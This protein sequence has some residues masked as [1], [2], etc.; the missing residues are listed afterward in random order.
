MVSFLILNNS[1]TKYSKKDID[2]GNT[3]LD[4][5][6]LCSGIREFFCLSY[7]IRKDNVLYIYFHSDLVLI[8]LDGSKLRFLGSDE[9]SQALLLLK[10]LEKSSTSST[11]KWER[12]T[13]GFYAMKLL[14]PLNIIHFIEKMSFERIFLISQSTS[15]NLQ[16]DFNNKNFTSQDFFI[17]RNGSEDK[18]VKG[19]FE[20]LNSSTK[21]IQ[22]NFSEI[23]SLEN[24]IL[25]INYL[26]DLE[27]KIIS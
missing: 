22:I 6:N 13:P 25:Y 2:L 4:I 11:E 9:R 26:I 19:L 23:K 20:N 10:V 14:N 3:P 17:I 27:N 8:K 15:T 1:Y 24:K 12:S 18:V 16:N 5:Y 7:S 21:I